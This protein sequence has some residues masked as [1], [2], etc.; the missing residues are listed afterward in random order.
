M[1]IHIL[2]KFL[3]KGLRIILRSVALLG[4]LWNQWNACFWK[5]FIIPG[6]KFL[7]KFAKMSLLE[8]LAR[9]DSWQGC[10]HF[11]KVSS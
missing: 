2:C 10:H 7:Q 4:N 5:G 1:P 11:W 8:S 3:Q 6:A 9:L